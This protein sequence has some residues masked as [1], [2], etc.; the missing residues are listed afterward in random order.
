MEK[1]LFYEKNGNYYFKHNGTVIDLT[2]E[3]L[4]KLKEELTLPYAF[5]FYGLKKI[6]IANIMFD[7]YNSEANTE[8]AEYEY[9]KKYKK[10]RY[11]AIYRKKEVKIAK[12]K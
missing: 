1:I 3:N 5:L 12:K 6:T 9:D 2:E 8:L 7:M 4:E 11:A 10:T